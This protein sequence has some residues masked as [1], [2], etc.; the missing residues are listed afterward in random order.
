M[1]CLFARPI[2]VAIAQNC[3]TAFPETIRRLR[4]GEAPVVHGD[5]SALR[6]FLYVGDAV[7]ATTR[8]ALV[9]GIVKPINIVRGESVQV[10]EVVRTLIRLLK[11]GEDIEFLPYKPNGMSLRF[12]NKAMLDVLGE[13][14][15]VSLEAGLHQ[16][17][18]RYKAVV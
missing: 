17:I 5:G 1:I 2:D 13:W 14:P 16:E 9:E 10:K 12:N 11:L 6:D 7:E 8:A 4:V 15:L 18:E 3:V